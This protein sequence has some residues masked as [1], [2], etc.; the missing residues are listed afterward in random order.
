MHAPLQSAAGVGGPQLP[1][2][3][4]R[5]ALPCTL[6]RQT[7]FRADVRAHMPRERYNHSWRPSENL[8]RFIYQIP[9]SLMSWYLANSIGSGTGA[10]MEI[11]AVEYAIVPCSEKAI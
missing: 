10:V 8:G 11:D 2:W 9:V 6:R 3:S 7:C 1:A 4:Q 5:T